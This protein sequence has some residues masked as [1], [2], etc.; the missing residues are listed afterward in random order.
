[1]KI[2]I[3]KIFT[4]RYIFSGEEAPARADAGDLPDAEF[5]DVRVVELVRNIQPKMSNSFVI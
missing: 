4:F 2:E 5:G 3:H 1:M